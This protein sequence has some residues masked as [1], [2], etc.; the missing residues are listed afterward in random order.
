MKDNFEL[1]IIAKIKTD[2]PTKFGIYYFK[3]KH[4]KFRPEIF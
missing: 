3:S 1:K 2:F 4:Q